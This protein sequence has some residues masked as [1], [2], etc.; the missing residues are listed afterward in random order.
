MAKCYKKI[1]P[2]CSSQQTKKDWT[3][4][5]RQSYKCLSCYHIRLSSK[6]DTALKEI[7]ISRIYHDYSHWK[8]TYKELSITYK[9]SIRTVQRYLDAYKWEYIEPNPQEIVL[10]IDTTYF[11][12][13]WLMVFKDALSTN[14][15]LMKV[16]GYETNEEY[17]SWINK[18]IEQWRIIKAMVVDGR[19]WL[20]NQ[21]RWFPVQLCNF[22]QQ[23]VVRRL[24]SNNPKTQAWRD[25][26]RIN[27]LMHETESESFELWLD[28]RYLKHKEFVV[29]KWVDGKWKNYYIHKKL[30]SAY[31]SLKRNSKY[32]FIYQNYFDIIDIP[33]TTNGLEWVFSHVKYKVNL[34]R[35]LRV[36]RKK[37]LV[38]HIMKTRKKPHQFVH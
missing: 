25:L 29:E 6:R 28:E 23:Q 38:I 13:R 33:N 16:V 36:D 34:H 22:H 14:I 15:L 30:R 21:D 26:K 9:L 31:H 27:N 32:L 2:L 17:I 37:K 5:W 35:W 18:L 7:L 20:L 4:K 12:N 10:I 3:R 19:K 8:Q 11:G 1:C 24:I